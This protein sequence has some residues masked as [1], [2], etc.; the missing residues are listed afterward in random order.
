M[1]RMEALLIGDI[2]TNG[3]FAKPQRKRS[4]SVNRR[5]DNA[6]ENLFNEGQMLA[7]AIVWAND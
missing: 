3:E 2:S 6:S 4:V 5:S 1:E 7:S